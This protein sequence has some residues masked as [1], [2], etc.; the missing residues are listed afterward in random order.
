MKPKRVSLRA[1]GVEDLE[2]TLVWV[3]DPE[4]THFTGTVYP[5][6][7]SEHRL[8]YDALLKDRSRRIFAIVASDGRHIGNVGLKDIDW[9]AR[10]AEII[11]YIG[12]AE[13]RGKGYGSE[14]FAAMVEFAFERMNLHR[15]YGIAYSYNERSI[16]CLEQC[17]F[18][19]EGVLKDHFFRD[20]RYHDGVIV[21]IVRDG[22]SGA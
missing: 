17:G 16:K 9:I 11:G 22:E 15:V 5:I 1:L 20:G 14:T 3:N 10:K 8:W 4:V 6:S 7:G 12:D 13:F 2:R 18:R 21:G 19:R